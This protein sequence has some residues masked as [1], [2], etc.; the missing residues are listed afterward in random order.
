MAA[1]FQ[2][3]TKKSAVLIKPFVDCGLIWFLGVFS[4]YEIRR[5]LAMLIST[6]FCFILFYFDVTGFE[7]ARESHSRSN[8]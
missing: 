5:K 2:G 4:T 6:V 7:P 8:L 1:N 3:Y